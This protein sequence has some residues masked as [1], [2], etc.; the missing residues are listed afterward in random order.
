MTTQVF[1]RVISGATA[2]EG[3][4][5]PQVNHPRQL[6]VGTVHPECSA[7][8]KWERQLEQGEPPEGNEEAVSVSAL[9]LRCILCELRGT[10]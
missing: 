5:Q 6:D 2:V 10:Q 4:W 1:W 7:P 3:R 8:T 9:P